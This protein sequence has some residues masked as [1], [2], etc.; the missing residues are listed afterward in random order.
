MYKTYLLYACLNE[1]TEYPV[2]SIAY[3]KRNHNKRFYHASIAFSDGFIIDYTKEGF[4]MG[5]IDYPRNTPFFLP[6]IEIEDSMSYTILKEKEMSIVER[7]ILINDLHRFID[8]TGETESDQ[9]DQIKGIENPR[10]RNFERLTHSSLLAYIFKKENPHLYDTDRVYTELGER[11][12]P[13]TITE[14]ILE[15]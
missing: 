15:K 6:V 13:G 12:L 8:Y 10:L 11:P 9:L 14:Y 1:H 7:E 4:H 5:Y 3:H 2:G